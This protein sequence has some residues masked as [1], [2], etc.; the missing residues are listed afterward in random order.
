MAEIAGWDPPPVLEDLDEFLV[1]H[2]N[3]VLWPPPERRRERRVD[4][5]SWPPGAPFPVGWVGQGLGDF[6]PGRSTY[7]CY[8]LEELPPIRLPLA[9]T[10]DWL[11]T[12]PEHERSIA[13]N[14][15]K[16]ALALGQLLAPNPTSLPSD[17]VHFFRSPSLWRRIRSCTGCYLDLDTAAVA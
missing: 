17:F 11:T 1:T 6:L 2:R 5:R 7:D 15:E 8:P 10:F 13:D 16:T 4:R 12:A 3:E 14:P 9:G